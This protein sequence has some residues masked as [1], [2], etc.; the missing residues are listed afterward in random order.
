MILVAGGTGTPGRTLLARLTGSGHGVR[1][2]TRDAARSAGL[3]ADVAVGDVLDPQSLPA[4]VSGCTAGV[5]AVHGF[6]GGRGGGPETVDQRGNANLVRAALDAGVHQFVLLSVFDTRPDHPMSLHRAKF[7]AEQNLYTSG[8][9]WTVLRPTSYAET[10]AGVIG[11]KLP[12]GGPALVFG[13]GRNPINFVS[14]RD[15]AALAERALTDPELQG[16]A[17]DISGPDNLTMVQF[18]HMLGATEIRHIPRLALRVLAVGVRPFAPALARQ[19]RAALVMDSSYMSVDQTALR[20]RFHDIAW[21]HA[22]DI[23][24]PPNSRRSS[25]QTQG[26]GIVDLVVI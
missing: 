22:A 20:S 16:Q 1:V 3:A 14:V 19:A 25:S 23:V 7:A 2:L 13:Q 26:L 8:L 12:T 4:A 5:S 9:A 15:V 21:H 6:T 10:W 17:L 24:G 11:S 18:V